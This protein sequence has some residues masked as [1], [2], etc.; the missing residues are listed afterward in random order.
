MAEGQDP[1]TEK[2]IA[3]FFDRSSFFA[4][5]LLLLILAVSLYV[6]AA[7]H[8]VDILDLQKDQISLAN[9]YAEILTGMIPHNN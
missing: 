4:I 7:P 2:V 1:K 9:I 5:L 8:P 6:V 3:G